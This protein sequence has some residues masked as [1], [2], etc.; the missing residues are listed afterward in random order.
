MRAVVRD[1]YGTPD[2]LRIE[3]VPVPAVAD[4]AVLV[5]V[6][7]TSV[8]DYDWHLL[9]GQPFV[10]RMV[11]PFRPKHRILGSDVAGTVEGV[12]TAVTSLR[13]GDDVYGDL[14]TSGFGAF[15]ELVSAPATSLTV[16]P[17]NLTF[18][19]AA[20]VPQAGGL[21]AMALRGRRPVRRGDEVLV[22]GGGGGVGTFAI[23]AAKALGATVTAVDAA[24]K[25]ET[26]RA[27]GA[28]RVVDYR[29]EDVMSGSR[30]YDVIID[31]AAHRP[32]STYRR[33]LE[34][35]GYAGLLGGSVPR[36]IF[37]MAA[38]PLSS[39]V[40]DRRVGVP[41]WRPNDPGDV[42]FLGRF[43]QSG[44]VSPVIDSVRPIEELPDALR[45]FGAQQHT[46]K[47]V[48]TM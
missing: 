19:Q 10:N 7:A 34:P 29:L 26:M 44:D 3:D 14:S 5:R 27:A 23:Q 45:R 11:A 30:T 43:L 24:H 46:G 31:V 33:C 22:N 16:K 2:V 28:D 39:L 4:D 35:G 1:S 47:I 25:L 42:A 38:G 8:N 9:T 15:A 41:L 17:G 6:R 48:I 20:A 21:A 12:G 37:T 32:I 40:V 36:V 18:E 13:P